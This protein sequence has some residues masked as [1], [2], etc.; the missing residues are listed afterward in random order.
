[1]K[2][3]GKIYKNEKRVGKQPHWTG[4]I[5]VRKREYKV[6]GWNCKYGDGT[7]FINIVFERKIVKKTEKPEEAKS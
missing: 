4:K 6:A 7:E 2:Y 3:N 1:L 5:E